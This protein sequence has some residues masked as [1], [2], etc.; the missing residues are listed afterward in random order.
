M[1]LQSKQI[2]VPH[3]F[4]RDI[5][6]YGHCLQVNDYAATGVDFVHH[7]AVDETS[8]SNRC[9]HNHL[10]KRIATATREGSYQ[11]LDPEAFGEAMRDKAT[12]TSNCFIF[13]NITLQDMTFSNSQICQGEHIMKQV[14]SILL[15][16]VLLNCFLYF[17]TGIDNLILDLYD[18][19]KYLHL[20]KIVIS[21]TEVS[22]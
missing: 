11:E 12:G 10:L 15:T 4:L 2:H 1:L 13:P 22:D 18:G 8:A 9:D 20:C 17:A 16:L 5:F 21:N 6:Y 14:Y 19:L 3:I 7:V